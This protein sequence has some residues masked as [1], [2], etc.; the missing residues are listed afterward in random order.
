VHRFK[1]HVYT[2]AELIRLLNKFDLKTIALYNSAN[3]AEYKLGDA[4][5]YL[6]AEKK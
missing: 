3:K 2:V 6:V 1:H 4:Q 5:I